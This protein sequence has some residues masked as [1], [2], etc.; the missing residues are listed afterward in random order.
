MLQLCG[1]RLL[2]IFGSLAF[3]GFLVAVDAVGDLVNIYRHLVQFIGV[4][5]AVGHLVSHK[6]AQ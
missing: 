2:L 3:A 1:G 4:T 5:V 6:A